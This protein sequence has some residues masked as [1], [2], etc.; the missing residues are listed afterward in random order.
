[1][2]YSPLLISFCMLA[3]SCQLNT[4]DEKVDLTPYSWRLYTESS[5]YV[6]PLNEYGKA[7]LESKD[8]AGANVTSGTQFY[9]DDQLIS[10]NVF[11]PT[12]VGTYRIKA[13]YKDLESK[14]ILVNVEEPLVKKIMVEY[15]TS[16]T[17]G[18]CPWIG[19][20]I[21]SLDNANPNVLSYS[22]HGQDPFEIHNTNPFQQLLQVYDRPAIRINRGYHRNFAAP[23]A[24]QPLIDSVYAFLSRQA[25][26]QLAI[27]SKIKGD[28]TSIQVK[29]LS[30]FTP[31][32]S[33]DSLYLTVVLVED[34]IVSYGQYN[35]FS[36]A[37]H[38]GNPYNEL[39]HPLE[40]YTNHNVLR[41]FATPIEGTFIPGIPFLAGSE[42]VIDH[43]L[44]SLEDISN[45]DNCSIIAIVHKKPGNIE[46]SSVLNAQIVA[47][48][49]AIGF[50]E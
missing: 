8:Q 17:C 13:I 34:D 3:I 21:D 24:V 39:P 12:A 23:I 9:I 49:E 4:E 28:Q 14:E 25:E 36:G 44:V 45:R 32:K 46:L 40:E 31:Y 5:S 43:F 18:W 1:M 22:I 7:V 19:T 10:G 41:R 15:F 35:A 26:V 20:R 48:G 16:E 29:L 30:Y 33:Y 37:N 2:K 50:N 42:K 27:D 38:V 6:I 47:L 11:V